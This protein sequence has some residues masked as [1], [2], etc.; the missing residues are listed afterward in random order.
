MNCSK[1]TRRHKTNKKIKKDGIKEQFVCNTDILPT[2]YRHS[3]GN[4]RHFRGIDFS[5]ICG[6]ADARIGIVPYFKKSCLNLLFV[7]GE[8]SSEKI[9]CKTIVSGGDLPIYFFQIAYLGVWS[10]FKRKLKK[11]ETKFAT[12]IEIKQ[13]YVML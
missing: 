2:Y 10:I 3:F 6:F 4:L 1:L 13:P 7:G 8:Q 11:E 12:S 5:K 9:N